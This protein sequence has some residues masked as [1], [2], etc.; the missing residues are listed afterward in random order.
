MKASFDGARK[1]LAWCFNRLAKTPLTDDQR[2]EMENLR[3]C[4]GGLLCM[5][6]ENCADD[7]HDLSETVRMDELHNEGV[8]GAGGVP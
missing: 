2:F 1:R 8:T 5:Y 3:D 6:D 7:C 4:I